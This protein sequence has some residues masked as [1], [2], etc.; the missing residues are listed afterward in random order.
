[1]RIRV[2]VRVRVRVS[3]RR[4]HLRLLLRSEL[5]RATPRQHAPRDHPSGARLQRHHH[6]VRVRVRVR[7]GVGVGVRVRVRIRMRVRVRVGLGCMR[8]RVSTAESSSCRCAAKVCSCAFRVRIC[9][10]RCAGVRCGARLARDRRALRFPLGLLPLCVRLGGGGGGGLLVLGDDPFSWR[11]GGP[12]SVGVER[13]RPLRDRA[14]A[15]GYYL[16]R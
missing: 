16:L 6:L 5:L 10:L 3:P 1:M 12:F 11:R 14:T 8:V 4:R 15:G 7:V 2:R 9:A 13:G